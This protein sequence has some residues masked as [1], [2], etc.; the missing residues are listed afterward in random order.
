MPRPVHS[1]GI[2]LGTTNCALAYLDPNDAA[3]TRVLAIEQETASGQIVTDPTL[4]SFLYRIVKKEVIDHPAPASALPGGWLVGRGARDQAANGD[5]RL[6]HSAKS[7]LASP[8]YPPDAPILPPDPTD[9]PESARLSPITASALLLRHLLEA[10]DRTFSSDPKDNALSK[11]NTPITITVPASFDATAQRATLEAATRA[12]LR[13]EQVTLLEEP[14]AAVYRCME[15]KGGELPLAPGEHLLVIDLGGGTL[16]FSLLQCTPDSPA[17]EPLRRVAVSDHIL[18][19]GDNIDLAAAHIFEALLLPDGGSLTGSAWDHLLAASR[20]AKERAFADDTHPGESLRVSIPGAGSG[21]FAAARTAEMPAA[22]LREILLEGFFPE[23]PREARPEEARSALQEWGLPYAADFAVTRYLADFLRDLPR[24]DT[25]LFNGGSLIPAI[26]RDRLREQI[27]VWQ[28]G[29]KP[30]NL[31]NPEPT[32]AVARGAALYGARH[33]RGVRTIASPTARA[34]FLEV[35]DAADGRR[36][37]CILPAGTA[38]GQ[39]VRTEIPGLKVR[40]NQRVRF[41]LL[42]ADQGATPRAGDWHDAK[43][44]GQN[45][46]L[47]S[48]ESEIPASK[49]SGSTAPQSLPAHIEATLNEL[50]LLELVLIA[51]SDSP[52]RCKL[53]FNLRDKAS[54]EPHPTVADTE[55]P[56]SAHTSANIRPPSL[57][58]NF[59]IRIPRDATPNKLFKAWEAALG[60][61]R[62]AWSLDRSRALADRLL[63]NPPTKETPLAT[64][65]TWL[66]A[67]GF[68][69]RPGFGDAEDPRRLQAAWPH[70]E[71]LNSPRSRRA[72]LIQSFLLWRRLAPG[73]PSDR[74]E[75]LLS[76]SLPILA[77]QRAPAELIR[78]LGCLRKVPTADKEAALNHLLPQLLGAARSGKHVTAWA[79]ALEDL[80]DRT[81]FATAAAH[82]APPAMVETAFAALSKL[83]WREPTLRRVPELFLRAARLTDEPS[84]NLAPKTRRAIIAHLKKSGIS[85]TRLAPLE[86]FVPLPASERAALLGESLPPGLILS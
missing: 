84:L 62:H 71:P 30:R 4:P 12:G 40:V 34:L 8:G 27:G 60:E 42:R 44:V 72:L 21:L 2:D 10:Y 53:E 23:C 49:R 22:Q 5:G 57:P 35:A 45:T 85:A 77:K 26:L 9:L 41:R 55:L 31:H 43:A 38:P 25:I 47:H 7:W 6:V 14:L 3:P 86:G 17:D 74:Q 78:L 18:L 1:I 52:L 32:L 24:I 70:A 73:L 83:D 33:L 58:L 69:L 39:R 11:S 79:Q 48:V 13:A 75:T 66:H 46:C 61:D 16:D 37:L 80:L 56:P 15:A 54:D 64:A 20:V 63:E 82:V 50:G 36:F 59:G 28:N 29:Y 68:T 76:D 65:E 81:P 19:G 51:E 67:V